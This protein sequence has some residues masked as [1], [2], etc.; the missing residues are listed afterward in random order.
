[1]SDRPG[2]CET[3]TTSQRAGR[4]TRTPSP[5]SLRASWR[6]RRPRHHHKREAGENDHGWHV[7]TRG[8]KH[9]ATPYSEP[10][11]LRGLRTS[12]HLLPPFTASRISHA[13]VNAITP[14]NLPRSNSAQFHAKYLGDP[15]FWKPYGDQMDRQFAD[16]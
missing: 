12:L 11:R 9:S 15:S 10:G 5:R 14:R 1:M 8:W 16:L 4:V 7:M 3:A 2:L 13:C 6:R